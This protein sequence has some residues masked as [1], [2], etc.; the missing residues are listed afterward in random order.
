MGVFMFFSAKHDVKPKLRSYEIPEWM[1]VKTKVQIKFTQGNDSVE[2]TSG[3]GHT[4]RIP[5]N[6]K[7]MSLWIGLLE[8]QKS[9]GEIYFFD[10]AEEDWKNLAGSRGYVLIREGRLVDA[11]VTFRN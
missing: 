3:T 6:E 11:V 7:M 8:A 2:I 1:L 10:S 5:V 4:E 9:G